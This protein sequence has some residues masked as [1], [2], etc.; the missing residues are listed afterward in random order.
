MQ[1]CLII[2]CREIRISCHAGPCSLSPLASAGSSLTF[3]S[4]LNVVYSAAHEFE[5]M[6]RSVPQIIT[7]FMYI[8]KGTNGSRRMTNRRI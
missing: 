5:L 4:P 1:M 8:N 6:P 3:I 2:F 7:I